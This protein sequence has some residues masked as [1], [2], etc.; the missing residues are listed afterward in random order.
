LNPWTLRSLGFATGFAFVFVFVLALLIGQ[1]A[2]AQVKGER[3]DNP[4]SR[5]RL[6]VTKFYD[7]PNP[8]TAKNPGDLIGSEVFDEYI[9]PEGVQAVRILYH[10]RSASG[11]DVAASGVVL[12]PEVKPPAGGWPVLAWAHSLNGVA[13]ECA[14]SLARNLQHGPFLAMY[15]SQGYAVV[16]T[17]FAGLGTSSRNAFSDT[18]SNAT[19]VVYSIPAARA[20]VPQ[21]GSRWIALGIGQGGAAAVGVA[22]LEYEMRDPNYLGSIAISSLDGAAE[23]YAASTI[24]G[25]YEAPLWLAYGIKSVYPDFNVKEILTGRALALYPR[26]EQ[27]CEDPGRASKLSSAELL[28]ATWNND[29]FVK[30][31]F[32]RSALGRK[33]AQGPLLI[34]SSGLDPAVPIQQ[35]AQVIARMCKQGDRVHFERY[36]QSDAGAVFGDSVRDQ[37]SWIQGRFAARPVSSNCGEQR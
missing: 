28:K 14:P 4:D 27:S 19:D 16:A 35:T 30:K 13:R 6:P 21:L 33:P 23:D 22:E 29:K 8:L 11:Q 2:P 32:S 34:I 26:V 3:A 20:A 12:Y 17:D 1:S 7:T 15:V 31:Y 37:I 25:F 10:S 5:H 9:L 24:P 18:P 36:P